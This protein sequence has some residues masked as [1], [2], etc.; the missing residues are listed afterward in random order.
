MQGVR[1][2]NPL[3]STG[4]EGPDDLVRPFVVP[5]AVRRAAYRGGVFS[6]KS[7]AI[8]SVF[9]EL[10]AFFRLTYAHVREESSASS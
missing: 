8:S 5:G 3:S 10:V 1:G 2:S 7:R 6:V 4:S 9:D